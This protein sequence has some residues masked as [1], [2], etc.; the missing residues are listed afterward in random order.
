VRVTNCP[1]FPRVMLA[2]ARVARK[3]GTKK[4][5]TMLPAGKFSGRFLSAWI[6]PDL[7]QGV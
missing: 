6:L 5:K 1:C 3:I 2:T 4:R 7:G